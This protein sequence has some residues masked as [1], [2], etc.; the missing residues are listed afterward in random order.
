V[1]ILGDKQEARRHAS[2]LVLAELA[3][4]ANV[5]VYPHVETILNN[6]WGA[7]REPKV[8]NDINIASKEH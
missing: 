8:R 6:I 1:A 4:H 2:V 3:R 5:K 7:M